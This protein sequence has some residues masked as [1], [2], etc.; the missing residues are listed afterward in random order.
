[1]LAFLGNRI[2]LDRL[3]WVYLNTLRDGPLYSIYNSRKRIRYIFHQDICVF[4]CRPLSPP[5]DV[6]YK[7]V[8]FFFFFSLDTHI[9]LIQARQVALATGRLSSNRTEF[10]GLTWWLYSK[11][12]V[13]IIRFILCT[14]SFFFCLTSLLSA[15]KLTHL[16]FH[17]AIRE[18]LLLA[19]CFFLFEA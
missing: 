14:I 3:V 11:W 6:K 9:F 18:A 8:F 15:V 16:P 2:N 17:V 5:A 1:M 13:F 7:A 10:W 19:F 4:G 12:E